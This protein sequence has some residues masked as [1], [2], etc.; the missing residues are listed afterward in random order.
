MQRQ[1]PTG[2]LITTGRGDRPVQYYEPAKWVG[3]ASYTEGRM[4]TLLLH[5]DDG[6]RSWR[7][8]G[9]VQRKGDE[10]DTPFCWLSWAY[11]L[12]KKVAASGRGKL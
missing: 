1:K 6:G 3:K 9:R 5:V 11:S 12:K 10:M 8:V 2:E 7:Q 4:K